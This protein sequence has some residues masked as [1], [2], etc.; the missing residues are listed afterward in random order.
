M[1]GSYEIPRV[2]SASVRDRLRDYL[3]GRISPE[4]ALMHLL[5]ATGSVDEIRRI[6]SGCSACQASPK[7]MILGRLVK[8]N[9]VGLR[10]AAAL[11]NMMMAEQDTS[12]SAITDFFDRA[13]VEA[14]EACDALYSLGSASIL[15]RAT[16]EITA[17]LL[18]W[19]L[20]GPDRDLLEIGC[21]TGR[22]VAALAGLARN[23]LGLDV[24]A[25]MVARALERCR[26]YKNVTNTKSTGRD[27]GFCAD[28]AFDLVLAVDSFPYIVAAGAGLAERHI[29]DAARVLK[30]SGSLVIFNYSYGGDL[31]ADRSTLSQLAVE[32][33]LSCVR[34][35]T[36]DFSLW[37]GATFLMRKV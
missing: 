27:L 28:E 20:V 31:D 2:L 8:D 15:S 29:A 19:E 37:D 26:A 22:V 7:L 14:P 11:A 30:P 3:E 32:N 9:A 1:T 36:R 13:V 24:S 21:G 34:M 6:L 25:G 33:G 35:G 16:S 4:V 12:L 10:R 18:E 17:R 23:V 5:I